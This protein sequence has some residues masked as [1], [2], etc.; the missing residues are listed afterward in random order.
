MPPQGPEYV[1]VTTSLYRRAVDAA[2]AARTEPAGASQQ[3]SAL[4]PSPSAGASALDR[5][6]IAL[7][8]QERWDLQQVFSRGQDAEFS[9]LTS[10]FLSGPQHQM[11]VRGR[12]PRHRGVFLGVVT[13]VLR[14]AVH[15]RLQARRATRFVLLCA[16]ASASKSPHL[17]PLT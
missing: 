4:S 10:G 14:D 8:Q 17:S 16:M 13:R 12:S 15:V 2:W 5:G 6:R 3:D 7:T 9:G 11:V 1:A